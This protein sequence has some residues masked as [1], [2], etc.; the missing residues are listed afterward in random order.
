M[1]VYCI[2]VYCIVFSDMG[3]YND[4]RHI[5]HA[6]KWIPINIFASTEFFFVSSLIESYNFVLLPNC[7]LLFIVL[8]PDDGGLVEE[9]DL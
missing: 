3:K 2:V 9:Y 5:I 8:L 4:I 7:F 6:V 1:V